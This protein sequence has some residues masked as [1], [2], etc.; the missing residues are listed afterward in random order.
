MTSF[1]L[2]CVQSASGYKTIYYLLDNHVWLLTEFM[3]KV[4]LTIAI[5]KK[6]MIQ[7]VTHI[8]TLL[9]Y[10]LLW[11]DELLKIKLWMRVAGWGRKAG[12]CTAQHTLTQGQSS[13]LDCSLLLFLKKTFILLQLTS[14]HL[15][16]QILFHAMEVLCNN[17][18]G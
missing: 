14:L 12:T 10:G 4:F 5:P 6:E 2:I 13:G 17:S 1:Y 8:M 7:I 9:P 11:R 16:H 18:P 15:L 3:L